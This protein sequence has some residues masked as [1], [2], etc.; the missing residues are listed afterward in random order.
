MTS[1]TLPLKTI[2]AYVVYTNNIGKIITAP[3]DTNNKE[4]TGDAASHNVIV[5]GTKYGKVLMP[6][7][8]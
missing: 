5:R 7:P 6:R 8:M 4:C 1:L 3:T 2:Y